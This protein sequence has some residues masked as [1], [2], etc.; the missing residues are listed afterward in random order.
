MANCK[1]CG[2]SIKVVKGNMSNLMSHLKIRHSKIDGRLMKSAKVNNQA[3]SPG[4]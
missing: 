1:E 2:K 4:C 3:I